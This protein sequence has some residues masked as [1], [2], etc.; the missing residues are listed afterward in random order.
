MVK[1]EN[2]IKLGEHVWQVLFLLSV[3]W[4]TIY[5][6]NCLMLAIIQTLTQTTEL[7]QR[8]VPKNLY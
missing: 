1:R 7:E 8:T 4:H 3:R 2:C 6:Y 5:S